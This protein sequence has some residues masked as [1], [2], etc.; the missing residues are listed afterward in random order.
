MQL[1]AWSVMTRVELNTGL[2]NLSQILYK[3]PP[4]TIQ[5]VRLYL[6]YSK[7]WSLP[8]SPPMT[9]MLDDWASHTTGSELQL[10]NW[11]TAFS[12]TPPTHPHKKILIFSNARSQHVWLLICYFDDLVKHLWFLWL[13]QIEPLNRGGQCRD[14]RFM[15]VWFI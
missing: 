1:S 13:I 3:Y 4:L 9:N 8:D 7:T 6:L 15:Q 5:S 11:T 12:S 14:Q 2:W 10:C